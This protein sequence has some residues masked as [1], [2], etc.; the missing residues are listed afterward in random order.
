MIE[1]RQGFDAPDFRRDVQL[2][3]PALFAGIG[4]R[5]PSIDFAR[6]FRITDGLVRSPELVSHVQ[7]LIEVG[8]LTNL[9]RGAL[10]SKQRITPRDAEGLWTGLIRAQV[11]VNEII[12]SV[13]EV[14]LS[15][16]KSK[17]RGGG[18]KEGLEYLLSG[19]ARG[20]AAHFDEATYGT[21]RGALATDYRS[22]LADDLIHKMRVLNGLSANTESAAMPMTMAP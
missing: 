6:L 15:G 12:R 19:P 14:G 17:S 3:P 5:L 13:V 18:P 11:P 1:I 2:L 22:D 4:G 10:L 7:S 21:V 9:M 8:G 20:L 16:I